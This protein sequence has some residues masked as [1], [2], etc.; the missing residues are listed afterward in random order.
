MEREKLRVVVIPEAKTL[1][2]MKGEITRAKGIDMPSVMKNMG[3]TAGN[4]FFEHCVKGVRGTENK[5]EKIIET[6]NS[7]D[8]GKFE[9][10]NRTEEFFVVKMIESPF[11]VSCSKNRKPSCHWVAGLLTGL[12]SNIDKKLHFE[13]SKCKIEGHP[14]CEF[15]AEK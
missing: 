2:E 12:F 10:G 1:M 3:I 7:T 14:H 8:Y 13:S 5:I 15:R 6:L 4:D 11:T 9:I